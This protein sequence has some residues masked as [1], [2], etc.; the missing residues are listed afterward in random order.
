MRPQ[1]WVRDVELG[2]L[3]PLGRGVQ[4]Q[5]AAAAVGRAGGGREKEKLLPLPELGAELMGC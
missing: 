2:A 5:K 1:K 4:A 3:P